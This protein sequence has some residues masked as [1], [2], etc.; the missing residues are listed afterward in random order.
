VNADL[1]LGAVGENG[2]VTAPEPDDEYGPDE[3]ESPEWHSS[4]APEERNGISEETF[5]KSRP[6]LEHIYTFAR[7]RIVAPWA[8]LGCVLARV[9][10]TVSPQVQLPPLTGGR[11]SLN[12]F[13]ALSGPSGSGKDAANAAA[14]DAIDYGKDRDDKPLGTGEGLSALFVRWDAKAKEMVQYETSALVYVGEVDTLGAIGSRQGATILPMLRQGAMGQTLGFSNAN[15]ETTRIVGTHKY[16]L[17]LV[18]G[19]QPTRSGILLND[20]NGGTPQRFIY[21]PTVDAETPEYEPEEPRAWKWT[22]PVWKS[23]TGPFGPITVPL[24]DY[25]KESIKAGRR[26]GARGEAPPVDSHSMLT[27]EKVAAGLAI[28]DG[29]TE[30]TDDDWALSGVIMTV[31]DRTRAMCAQ[32][33]KQES[34]RENIGKALAEAERTV[35]VTEQ[36]DEVAVRKVSVRI[37]SRLTTD[38]GPMPHSALRSSLTPAEREHWDPAIT[39]L[40]RAGEVVRDKDEYRGRERIRYRLV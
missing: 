33:L 15:T 11:A 20:R 7:A 21:M 10:V 27:R 12:L 30:V 32:A 26:M 25:V 3:F 9:L 17:C 5:W 2:E 18:A 8:L 38:G 22:P 14:S 4:V 40:V 31:S 37:K 1:W 28:L 35:I 6:V 19:M 24:P 16:R 23:F 13:V 34:Q 39:A 29:R 36:L